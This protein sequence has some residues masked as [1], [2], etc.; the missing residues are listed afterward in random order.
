L[1]AMAAAHSQSH[2]RQAGSYKTVLTTLNRR[3]W[4]ASDGGGTFTTA[5]PA[6]RLLQPF[7]VP[8]WVIVYT[9][10]KTCPYRIGNDVTCHRQQVLFT[11]NGPV[12]KAFLP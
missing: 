5:S 6:S 8:Q 4:L 11:S 2:R 3:S 1:P 7:C 12:M 10:D 9:P